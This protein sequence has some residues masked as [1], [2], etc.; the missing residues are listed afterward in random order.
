MVRM[1]LVCY[2]RTYKG[3]TTCNEEGKASSDNTVSQKHYISGAKSH[4]QKKNR[5]CESFLVSLSFPF[6][7]IPMLQAN[8]NDLI[9]F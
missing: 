2:I 6:F 9:N 7:D 5:S 8:Y 4:P 1:S 3:P